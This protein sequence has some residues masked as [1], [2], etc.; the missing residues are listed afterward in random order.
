MSTPQSK[1][2]IKITN[3]NTPIYMD[4]S[5]TTPLDGRVLKVMMPYF[6]EKF[7]NPHSR[8][9]SYGWEAEKAVEIAR[10][11]VAKLI[12]ADNSKSII[13]TSGAT[14][15]NNLALKG[16][17]GFYGQEKKH[18]I[19]SATE[20][21]CILDVCRNL[22]K[23]GFSITYLPVNREGVINLQ[24]LENAITDNTILVSIMMVNNETGVIQPVEDI[25]AICR[26]RNVLFHSD[27]A[28][29]CGKLKIDVEKMNIDLASISGHKMYAPKGIGALYVRRKPRI[30]LKSL[31]NGGG[32]ERGMRSGTNPTPLIVGLG[33][34]ADIIVN[35]LDTDTK[36]ISFLSDLFLQGLKNNLSDIYLNGSQNSK[37]PHIMNI[38]FAYVEGESLIL[39]VKDL[40]I[41]S[42]SAC[43]S[44]SLEPSYV[45]SA[46]NVDEE[47]AH[48]SLRFSFG[49]LT[50]QQEVEYAIELITEKVLKLRSLSP[51]W[52]MVQEGIDLKQIKWSS[53]H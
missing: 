33:K 53:H 14:E 42:G 22:E 5:A 6:T 51:L 46:M 44:A 20:H 13:F 9:H 39:A 34:A 50:T 2:E 36:H 11:Q 19:T 32:Q 30:R 18:I 40:A 1:S 31:F 24:Q 25:G 23:D 16:I 8:T 35:E 12:N 3:N 17:A 7:G 41:S 29:A 45:M 27:I 21:K 26:K 47:L 37:V 4:Y 28:Q 15:S 49:R 48:T 10:S 43:T 52:E 38:S